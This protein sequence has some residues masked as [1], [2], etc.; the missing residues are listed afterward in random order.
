MNSVTYTRQARES[1][2]LQNY[3]AEIKIRAE[4]RAGELIPQQITHGGDPKSHAVTL[5]D[6]GI[7]KNQS[8][9]W[10][11][12][13]GLDAEACERYLAETKAGGKELTSAGVDRHRRRLL[14]TGN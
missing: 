5:G 2:T 11:R 4:R 9:R 13:A 12:I 10:Q 6:L 1:L 14:R 7:H 3:C 8:S